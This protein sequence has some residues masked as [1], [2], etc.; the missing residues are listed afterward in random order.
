MTELR[1]ARDASIDCTRDGRHIVPSIHHRIYIYL[2]SYYNYYY[3]TTFAVNGPTTWNWL[4]ASLRSSDMT[5]QAFIRQL[6]TFLFQHSTDTAETTDFCNTARRHCGCFSHLTPDTT[7]TQLNNYYSYYLRRRLA[8]EGIVSLGVTLCVCLC[9]PSR[10]YHVS[11]A[12]R[13]SLGGED[14]AL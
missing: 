8:S 10:L 11:T 3:H 6:Q 5:L 1:Q 14:N 4:P 2:I 7:P 13:I 12:N 9:P